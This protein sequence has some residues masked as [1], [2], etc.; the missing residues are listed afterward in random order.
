MKGAGSPWLGQP[1]PNQKHYHGGVAINE[2]QPVLD[3]DAL[4]EC[5][6]LFGWG[7]MFASS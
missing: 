3:G 5:S 2:G 6:D 4:C 1:W 7:S